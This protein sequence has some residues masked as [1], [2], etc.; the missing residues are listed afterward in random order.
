MK[1]K[2]AYVM[3]RHMSN[4][5]VTDLMETASNEV[6]GHRDL[7]LPLESILQSKDKQ[8]GSFRSKMTQERTNKCL[9]SKSSASGRRCKICQ[10]AEC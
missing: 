5:E 10:I 9:H 3:W 2:F 6:T 8:G 1:L 4:F 7:K